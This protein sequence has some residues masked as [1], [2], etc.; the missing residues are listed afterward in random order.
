M[1]LDCNVCTAYVHYG[2]SHIPGSY[3]VMYLSK[4]TPYKTIVVKIDYQPG[5]EPA[6]ETVEALHQQIEIWHPEDQDYS[7]RMP[8]AS[9]KMYSVGVTYAANSIITFKGS[10]PGNDIEITISLHELGHI[11]GFGQT[12]ESGNIINAEFEV[13]INEPPPMMW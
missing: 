1:M 10:W 4:Y 11:R 9:R 6:L 2:E 7:S 5:V 13:D 8:A 12:N 3:N